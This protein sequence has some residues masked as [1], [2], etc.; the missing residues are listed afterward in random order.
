MPE[1]W[2]YK[3]GHAPFAKLRSDTLLLVSPGRIT[4]YVADASAAAQITSRLDDFPK[5]LELY[6]VLNVF[7]KNVVTLEGN[8]WRRHRKVISGAFTEGNNRLVWDF[9]LQQARRMIDEWT[10]EDSLRPRSTTIKDASQ[11]TMRLSLHVISRSGFGLDLLWPH[12]ER[13]NRLHAKKSQESLRESQPVLAGKH[14]MS[15]QTALQTL[16]KGIFLLIVCPRWLAGKILLEKEPGSMA[17]AV[18]NGY[19]LKE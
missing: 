7:G 2:H 16:L 9:S 11:D 3:Q 14:I 17:N 8:A 15:F 4:L 18:K 19:P 6:E 10:N 5:A 1:P 12:Q 13:R